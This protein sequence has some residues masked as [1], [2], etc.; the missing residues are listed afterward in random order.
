VP[1]IA[2]AAHDTASAVA[3]LSLDDGSAFLI[4]GSWSLIGIE[5][6][7][8]L[9][10][11]AA[12]CAGFGNE[13]G[14][15]GRTFLVKSLNGLQLIQKLRT[16]WRSRTGADIDFGAISQFARAAL[17]RNDVPAIVPSDPLFFNPADVIEA[18]TQFFALK[19]TQVRD[20]IGW[21]ASSIY[22]GLAAEVGHAARSIED[23]L[24]HPIPGFKL[25]GG[26][27]QDGLLCEL[28]AA[29]LKRP[30]RIGPIEASAWG[31]AMVQLMGLGL[32]KSLDEGRRLV[33]GSTEYRDLV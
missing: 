8:P 15:E 26:G 28:V 19:D 30:V 33:E 17:R 4:C 25:C 7:K 20:E 3:A 5:H 11:E 22:K 14:V 1:V 24:G 31:N 16:A 29:A 6:E 10:T 21:L 18:M 9:T 32:V 12:Q 23:M 13:G 27:A 2:C